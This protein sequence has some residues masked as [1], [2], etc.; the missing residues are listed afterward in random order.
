MR[1]PR[2]GG[3]GGGTLPSPMATAFTLVEMM[4]V[5]AIIVVL[6]ALIAPSMGSL[7]RGPLITQASDQATGLFNLARQTAITRNASV[8]V[9]FYQYGD[10]SFPGEQA[11]VAASGKYRACQLF[12]VDDLGK[13]TALGKVEMLPQAVIA[14]SGAPLS[15]LLAAGQQK[16]WTASDPMLSLPRAGLNYNCRSFRFRPD[17]S[18]DLDA[19]AR[20]FITLHNVNDGDGLNAPPRNFV[21]V[22]IDPISGAATS[23]R[24]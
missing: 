14:D 10:P 11:N 5:M 23:Y 9:R 1:S 19:S 24:P 6:V 22:Q 17:G 12:A 16:V 21:T 3:R 2:V 13:C 20:W 7:L 15:T 18:T 4:A 8:E